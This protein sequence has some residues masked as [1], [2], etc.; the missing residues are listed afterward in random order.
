MVSWLSSEYILKEGLPEIYQFNMEIS[1]LFP[2]NMG[3]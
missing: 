3:H 2:V 1:L